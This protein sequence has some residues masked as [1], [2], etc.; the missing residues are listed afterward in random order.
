MVLPALVF[1]GSG[2]VL[3]GMEYSNGQAVV[4]DV[5]QDLCRDFASSEDILYCSNAF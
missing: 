4:Q 3:C 5:S 2:L 1:F